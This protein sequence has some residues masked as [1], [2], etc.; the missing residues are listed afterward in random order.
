MVLLSEA[1]LAYMG[2][3]IKK[4]ELKDA[5]EA[6]NTAMLEGNI[7]PAIVQQMFMAQILHETGELRWSR[8]LASGDAYNPPSS[9][10]KRLGNTQ[11]G[12]GPRFKGGGWMQLT[13]RYN[14]TQFTKEVGLKHGYDLVKNPERI[15][16]PKASALTAVWYWNSRKLTDYAMPG[17]EE[18][19]R[20]V[21][22]RINGGYNGYDDRKKYWE[23]AKI[24]ITPGWLLDNG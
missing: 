20:E 15:T 10:A 1:M 5:V 4:S 13:G 19:F 14:Y 12:D 2:P 21:T 8:E 9:L 17:T 24:C 7:K 22:R 11:P 3:N 16:E 6:L 18:A 23:R